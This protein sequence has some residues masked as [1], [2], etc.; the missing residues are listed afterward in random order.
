PSYVLEFKYTKDGQ[1]DLKQLAKQG[2]KQIMEKQYDMGLQGKV[3][4][5]GLA[6]RGKEVEVLY[7]ERSSQK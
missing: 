5:I 6:H 3:Y 2:I 1:V 7:Q 4:Y